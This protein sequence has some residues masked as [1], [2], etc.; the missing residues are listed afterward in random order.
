MIDDRLVVE[1]AFLFA[2]QGVAFAHLLA[3]SVRGC[4]AKSV[5]TGAGSD[6]QT[7]D[8]IGGVSTDVYHVACL[9]C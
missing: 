6:T 8:C 3:A 5:R 9:L 2:A 1:E 4:G 7:T